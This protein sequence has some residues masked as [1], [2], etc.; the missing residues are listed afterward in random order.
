[1]RSASHRRGAAGIDWVVKLGGSLATAADL[2]DWLAMLA[3]AACRVVIV[4]GGGPFADQVRDLQARQPFGDAVAHRMAILAMEQFGLMLT[5]LEPRLRL[6]VSARTISVALSDGSTAVWMPS[7]MAIGRRE[8]PESWDVTSDSLAAWF[9]DEIGA[10]NLL[11][12]KSATPPPGPVAVSRLVELD[13][14]DRAF[15]GFLARCHVNC[16]CAGATQKADV[17][18]LLRDGIAGSAIASVTPLA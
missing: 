16:W 7:R 12:V 1:M 3:E 2:R 8:I 11:L 14:V 15:P 17:A 5:D 18:N 13:L 6:A 4:P 10:A 9:T